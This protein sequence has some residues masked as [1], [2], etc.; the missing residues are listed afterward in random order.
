M[1]Q[2]DW[3]SLKGELSDYV[4]KSLKG[5]IQDA[6]A[7]LKAYGTAIA[8]GLIIAIR[9]GDADLAKELKAQVKVLAEIHRVKLNKKVEGLMNKFMDVGLRI[10]MAAMTV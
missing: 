2:I 9:T 3:K 10:G 4:V 6:E 7:D 5:T 8:S 1:A